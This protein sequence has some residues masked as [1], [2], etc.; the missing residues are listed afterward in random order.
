MEEAA[1]A[2]RRKA[3][4]L[5][6]A[7]RLVMTVEP[8][9]EWSALTE[10]TQALSLFSE[11]RLIDLRMAS[12]KPGEAGSAALLQFCE[13]APVD[14]ALLIV[15]GRLESRTRQAKWFKAVQRAG[16]ITEYKAI[17]PE[18][19][20]AWIMA[21]AKARGTTIETDAAA[22]LAY[23]QEGNLLAAAQEIDKLVLLFAD[24]KVIRVTHVEDSITD[25]ARFNIYALVEHCVAG[26]AMKALRS[27]NGLKHEGA[28]P[29]LILWALAKEVRTLYRL[30]IAIAA[31]E[32]RTQLFN[33]YRIWPK[34]APA[35]K[36]A[37]DRYS[38]KEWAYLLRQMARLD[39]ILK[40][41]EADDLWQTL[42]RTCLYICGHAMNGAASDQKGYV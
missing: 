15:C 8:R 18:K 34:R 42:E 14:T 1:D 13:S 9:F 26:N 12:G 6:Y 7:E 37:L 2:L 19:L 4:E 21:R 17:P 32:P 24:E 35:M 27:L 10:S 41:R 40:G 5:G 30:A 16:Q 31:G 11:R 29:V 39:R 25:N 23:Y 28:E 20:P 22:L 36:A 38:P 33:S 3:V